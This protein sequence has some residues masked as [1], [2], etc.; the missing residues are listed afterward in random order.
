MDLCRASSG[1]SS[2]RCIRPRSV[3]R[4]DV[5]GGVEVVP[6]PANV[7]L[8]RTVSGIRALT[9]ARGGRCLRHKLKGK[10]PVRPLPSLSHVRPAVP[11]MQLHALPGCCAVSSTEMLLLCKTLQTIAVQ[12]VMKCICMSTRSVF[13]LD[14][15]WSL[16][17]DFCHDLEEHSCEGVTCFT[18]AM[19]S[20]VASAQGGGHV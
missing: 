2:S 1:S 13:F 10:E 20:P 17:F 19:V 8:S 7:A 15:V 3:S 9:D 18:G 5:G 14:V 16:S 6:P 11:A 12:V 4:E